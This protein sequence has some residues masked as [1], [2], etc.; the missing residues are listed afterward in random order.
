[1][2]YSGKFKGRVVAELIRHMYEYPPLGLR[3]YWMQVR[4]YTLC[5]IVALH[6]LFFLRK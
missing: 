5:I 3:A 6:T 4:P 2:S 1:M